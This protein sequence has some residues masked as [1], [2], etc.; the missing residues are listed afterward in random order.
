MESNVKGYRA[1][2]FRLSRE[3]EE[4]ASLSLDLGENILWCRFTM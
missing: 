2:E 1:K 4:E 3:G